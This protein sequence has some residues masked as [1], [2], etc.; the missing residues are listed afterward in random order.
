MSQQPEWEYAGH[1]GD[2]D[3]IAYGGGFVYADKT[4]V[5]PPELTWFE[6]GSDEEWKDKEGETPL[7]VY[8][9]VLDPPR[10]KTLT[11]EGARHGYRT[12]DLPASDRGKT[13]HWYEEWFVADLG[14]VAQS[15]NVTKFQL[16][17]ELFS[18]V[19]QRRALAYDSLIHHFGVHE[20]DQYPIT[21][22]EDE[23]YAKYAE[24][25]KAAR[26]PHGS[27]VG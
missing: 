19:P 10:F 18:K 23:A 25:M 14:K 7:Q 6:P 16:L 21:M 17:R 3:P 8:R 5:Y 27:N 12:E 1:V 26:R 4:G 13:W 20:F 22:T 15:C 11:A 9:L 24:E 2:V